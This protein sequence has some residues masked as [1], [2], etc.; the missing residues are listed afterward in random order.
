[1][2]KKYAKVLIVGFIIG[3]APFMPNIECLPVFEQDQIV[4]VQENDEGEI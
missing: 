4:H 3:M 2:F 1:M